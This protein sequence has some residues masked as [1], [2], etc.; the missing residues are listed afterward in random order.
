MKQ[1]VKRALRSLGYEVRRTLPTDAIGGVEI[2]HDLRA[3]L[4]DRPPCLIV[5]VGANVGQTT[6]TMLRT[7]AEPRVIAFEPSPVSFGALRK[8]YGSHPRVRIEQ[9]GLGERDG[10]LPFNIS[11]DFSVNDSFLMPTSAVPVESLLVPVRTL[12]RYCEEQGI[13]AIDLLKVDTQ[14][15]DLSVLRGARRL[16]EGGQIRV[17]FVEVIL[18]PMY[19]G[20]P[21]LTDFLEFA[22]ETGYA[23][24][25]FYEQTYLNKELWYLNACFQKA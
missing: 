15:Y 5:D 12:D 8:K 1:L 19:E 6:E 13:L 11:S 14:G 25:G 9:C 23:L 4:A 22:N 10:T 2:L 24:V 16:L 20:Q 18:A 3:L 7:F 21:T 17:F